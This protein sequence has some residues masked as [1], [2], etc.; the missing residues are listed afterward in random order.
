MSVSTTGRWHSAVALARSALVR[1][2][3]C[4]CTMSN[5]HPHHCGHFV[6]EPLREAGERGWHP[7]TRLPC[8]L[9]VETPLYGGSHLEHVHG[10]IT[11]F[12]F[13]SHSMTWCSIAEY[14]CSK[15]FT[16]RFC[17]P[18]FLCFTAVSFVL[19]DPGLQEQLV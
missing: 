9:T 13:F 8:A 17:L 15:H 19:S 10:N 14:S 7:Q 16:I 11:I 1:G 2:S 4:C 3:Q 12:S 6:H 18:L 5:L